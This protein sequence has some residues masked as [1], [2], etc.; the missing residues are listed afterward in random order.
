M[1]EK[2]KVKEVDLMARVGVWHGLGMLMLGDEYLI[3][4]DLEG[5]GE[6]GNWGM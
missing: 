4:E 2:G 1:M 3:D 5:E 6:W